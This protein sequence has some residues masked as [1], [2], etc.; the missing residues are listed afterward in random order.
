M[1]N[2]RV[3]YYIPAIRIPEVIQF[4][5][6]RLRPFKKDHGFADL[7]PLDIF[8][9][10][11]TLVEVNGFESGDKLDYGISLKTYEAMEQIKFGYFFA[12][13]S[14]SDS[15]FGFIYAELFDYFEIIEKAPILQ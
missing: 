12:Y 14:Y 6:F 13:P 1:E 9:D 4:N 8:D 10:K 15:L 11:G 2:R 5:N 3:I 7:L